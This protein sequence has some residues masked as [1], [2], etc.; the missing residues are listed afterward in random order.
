M[1]SPIDKV[2]ATLDRARKTRDGWNARCPAHDDRNPSLSVRAG[3]N[4]TVLLTCH[5][6]CHTDAVVAAMGLQ[7]SDLFPSDLRASGRGNSRTQ[8]NFTRAPGER[9]EREPRKGESEGSEEPALELVPLAGF[10]VKRQPDHPHV[11]APYY[12]RRVVSLLGGHGGAGKTTL[13]VAHAA[14]VAAGRGWGPFPV[15]KGR[16]VFLSFEDEGADIVRTLQDVVVAY[17]LPPD[18]VERNLIVYDGTDTETELAIE[19]TEGGAVRLDF[20]AMMEVVE[21][22]CA[23]ADLVIIDNASDTFGGNENNRRQVKAFIRRLARKLARANDAAV[24]LLV[25]INKDAAKGNGKG[26]NYSGNTAW[27][28]GS[29]SR[30]ALV[31]SEAGIELLHEKARWMS[32]AEPVR[33]QRETGGVLVPVSAV[34]LSAAQ[35]SAQA[36][37][38]QAD[39]ETVIE[40]LRLS[41]D[42]PTAPTGPRTTWHVLALM[43]EAPPWL[44]EKR[45]KRR[46]EAALM[47][48]ER[49]GRI[50]RVLRKSHSRH[51][52]ERWAVGDAVDRAA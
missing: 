36:L 24:V 42:I 12:P 39:A 21:Q 16:V 5:A 33:L 37:I 46:T 50:H 48:L 14:H 2:L 43:P 45:N 28:N 44:R 51:E 29:R 8:R 13:A 47:L 40:L 35:A 11:V 10:M 6:G 7:M 20:T 19:S 27:H 52:V 25:H 34:E 4:G 23:G 38:A 31:E 41:D 30:L 9:P 32:K 49:S 26:E 15:V 1:S 17:G 22:V 3:E 18:E